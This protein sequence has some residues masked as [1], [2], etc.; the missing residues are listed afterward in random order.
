MGA[1]TTAFGNASVGFI[2]RPLTLS[3]TIA[4]AVMVT[5]TGNTVCVTAAT[6]SGISLWAGSSGDTI[7][8][9]MAGIALWSAST[10]VAIFAQVDCDGAGLCITHTSGGILR[11]KALAAAGAAGDII[12]VLLANGF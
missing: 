8:V 4:K 1:N 6:A 12:P 3:A 10:T 5:D 2:S 7:D 11:G 9:Q